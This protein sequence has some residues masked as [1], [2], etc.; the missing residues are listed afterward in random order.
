[1]AGADRVDKLAM[2]VTLFPEESQD[3]FDDLAP[4]TDG[5]RRA[6]RL[7]ALARLGLEVET[8]RRRGEPH[9][10]VGLAPSP[11]LAEGAGAT[12]AGEQKLTASMLDWGTDK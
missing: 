3:L 5:K 8:E 2:H 11:Q 1:M 4:I 9:R 12:P 6:A 10:I 7:K